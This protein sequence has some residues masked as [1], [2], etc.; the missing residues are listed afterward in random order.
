MSVKPLTPETLWLFLCSSS[1]PRHFDDITF[2]YQ[3]LAQ[4]GVPSENIRIFIDSPTGDFYL[5]PHGIGNIYP[6]D[7]LTTN[8]RD[9]NEH[10]NVIAIVG[11]H[12]DMKGVGEIAPFELVNAIRSVPGISQA[13]LILTQCFCGIFNYIEANRDPKLVIIGATGLHPSLSLPVSLQKPI[14][15]TA[16]ASLSNWSANIFSLMFFEWILAPVDVDGDGL[17]TL[18]DAYKY[19]GTRS[20]Q[21]LRAAKVGL[22]QDAQNLS[23]ALRESTE[24]A[25]QGELIQFHVDSTQRELEEKLNLLYISQEPWLLHA[26][27]AREMAV[28]LG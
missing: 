24:K 3:A 19:A 26:N 5:Q 22:F 13:A 20:N 4:K 6:L 2:G 10:Q 21:Y 14:Q 11:G 23:I 7:E 16:Q 28:E 27:L 8:L 25:R 9:S 15:G 18:V 17:H 12:G 1:E